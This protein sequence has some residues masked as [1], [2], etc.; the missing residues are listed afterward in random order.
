LFNINEGDEVMEIKV[1]LK[2]L[3]LN[4]D[5][6]VVEMWTNTDLGEVSNDFYSS[7]KPHASGLY[8][9]TP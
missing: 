9:F 4:G 7:I 5:C 3:G 2:D 6:Q 1:N 8:K